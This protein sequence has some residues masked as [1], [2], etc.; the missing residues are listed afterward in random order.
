MEDFNFF[1]IC[2]NCEDEECCKEPYYAFFAEN[3][4]RRIIDKIKELKIKLLDNPE[5]FFEIEEIKYNKN[6]LTFHTIKKINGKCIFLERNRICLIHDVKPFD[7]K[8]WPLTWDYFP[9][10]NKLVIYLG[11]CPLTKKMPKS[12][13]DSTIE[14]IKKE[15][16]N[17]TKEELIAYSLL[18]RD[19]TLR[20]I[21]EIPNFL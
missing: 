2:E 11:E 21:K 18:E 8:I 14:E 6:I 16:K 5:D 10:D 13:I 19:E 15:L 4:K 7:C 20:I 12:W 1:K 3:E 17:R 9:K